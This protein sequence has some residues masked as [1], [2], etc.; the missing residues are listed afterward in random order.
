[1]EDVRDGDLDMVLRFSARNS[2]LRVGDTQAC[3]AGEFTHGT[4]GQTFRFLGCDVV[5]VV[6]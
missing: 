1:V 4:S 6:R 5:I 2:D 3:V